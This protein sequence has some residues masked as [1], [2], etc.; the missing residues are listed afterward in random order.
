M[1][2]HMQSGAGAGPQ[3]TGAPQG[4]GGKD[5]DVIDAEFEVKK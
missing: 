5:D 2:Q 3:A 1:A 4:G